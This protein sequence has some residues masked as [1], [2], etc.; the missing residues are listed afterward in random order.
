MAFLCSKI[1]GLDFSK[2]KNTYK[3]FASS[4]SELNK[5]NNLKNNSSVL[6]KWGK[7]S[8]TNANMFVPNKRANATTFGFLFFSEF[9]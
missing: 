9:H 4:Y 6:K 3:Y 8:A 5:I 7:K 2:H 1:Q